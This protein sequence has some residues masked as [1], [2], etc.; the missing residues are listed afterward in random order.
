MDKAFT[1][2]IADW[3]ETPREER[4]VRKGAELLLRI[5]GNRH[6]YQLAMIRP[7]TAH[8]HV[9]A[10]LKKFL[11]IR[12]DGHTMESVRQMDS[13]LIP[14]VQNIITTRQDESED[15]PEETD[16]TAPAHRGKRS[17]HNELPEEIRAIYERGGELFEKIKQIFTELQQMENAPA[18]DRYE[19]LKVLKPLVKE[20]TDGWER[21]DNYNSDML[22]EEAVEAVDEAPEPGN[23][24]KRVSAARKFISTHV[25]KL[26]TLLQAETIDE[27]EVENERRQ[28]AE[29][30]A[31]IAE[32]GGS[33]KPDFAQRIHAL[34]VDIEP[35]TE[36][37]Q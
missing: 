27:A 5:N 28:I 29:R 15:A 33:F 20:Y 35:T 21:Y 1:Q 7:E 26:E 37:E 17:D 31:F 36:G 8:N 9:E 6:I 24:V 12:L 10:D 13:E 2:D 3:L 32:T 4:D 18:C 34:G 11:Q 19:K 14:K 16:D 23:E 30:M 25:A 22:Q